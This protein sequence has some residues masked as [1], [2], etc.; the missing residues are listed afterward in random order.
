MSR[1]TYKKP[2]Q[3]TEEIEKKQKAMLQKIKEDNDKLEQDINQ[4]KISIERMEQEAI[5]RAQLLEQ[6]QTE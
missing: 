2:Q 3:E 4:L 5:N 6:M 1:S